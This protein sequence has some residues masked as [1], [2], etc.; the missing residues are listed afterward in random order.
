MPGADLAAHLDPVAVREAHDEDG[1]VGRGG[2]DPAVGLLG[3]AGLADDLDVALGLEELAHASADD[4]VI[5]EEEHANHRRSLAGRRR[6]RPRH[7]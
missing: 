5:I 7:P 3:G 4:F 1:D 6:R 2:R